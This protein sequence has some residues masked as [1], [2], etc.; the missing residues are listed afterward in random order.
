MG[1]RAVRSTS[2]PPLHPRRGRGGE[3]RGPRRGKARNPSSIHQPSRLCSSSLVPGPGCS[4]SRLGKPS[5]PHPSSIQCDAI[6][7]APAALRH[8]P[9]GQPPRH[10]S[11]PVPR[12]LRTS[13]SLSLSLSACLFSACRLRLI[14]TTDCPP[15]S[16]PRRTP[17]ASSPSSRNASP[18][19]AAT[20]TAS[21]SS[22]PTTSPS[23]TPAGTIVS[24]L[25]GWVAVSLQHGCIVL[26]LQTATD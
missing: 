3:G 17:L 12:A 16:T 15:P 25:D 11:L 8:R 20:S 1:V 13:P 10:P 6:V 19:A 2:T 23:S 9:R 26:C 21:T 4:C 5:S 14:P 7:G 18:P 24:D 22:S